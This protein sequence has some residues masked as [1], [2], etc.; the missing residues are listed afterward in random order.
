[1]QFENVI[2]AHGSSLR[3]KP[4]ET[5]SGIPARPGPGRKRPGRGVPGAASAQGCSS[6]AAGKPRERGL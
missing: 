2:L 4:V 5:G 1:M 3:L 6:N